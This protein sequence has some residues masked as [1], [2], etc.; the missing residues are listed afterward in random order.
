MHQHDRNHRHDVEG[1]YS[2]NSYYF[3]EIEDDGEELQTTSSSLGFRC[4]IR[5]FLVTF[6]TASASSVPCFHMI[7][8]LLGSFTVSLLTFILPPLFHLF[9][10]SI[11]RVKGKDIPNEMMSP[12]F[13]LAK[14]LILLVLG[15]VITVI[16]TGMTFS[17]ILHVIFSNNGQC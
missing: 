6:T 4:V 7:V 15:T 16:G 17:Q 3:D 1:L 2:E 12:S 5:L 14:D 11:P 8:S 10:I 9:I 13:Q